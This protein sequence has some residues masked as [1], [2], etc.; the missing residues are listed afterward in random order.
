MYGFDYT[1]SLSNCKAK[2][3]KI[4]KRFILHRGFAMNRF[5]KNLFM[6]S[7]NL[8]TSTTIICPKTERTNKDKL[9]PPLFYQLFLVSFRNRKTVCGLIIYTYLMVYRNFNQ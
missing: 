5:T 3:G 9:L 8:N 2:Y 7:S 6:F 1:K 4:C